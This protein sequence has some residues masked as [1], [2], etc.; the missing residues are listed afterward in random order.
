[1]KHFEHRHPYRSVL[2]E[3][4]LCGAEGFL[5]KIITSVNYTSRDSKSLE[6]KTTGQEVIKAIKEAAS[7]LDKHKQDLKKQRK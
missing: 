2:N 6:K 7:D 1:M 4:Q 3:C 5:S